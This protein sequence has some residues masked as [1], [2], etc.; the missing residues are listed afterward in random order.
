MSYYL[1]YK[2][3]L[4]DLTT[5]CLQRCKIANAEI[6]KRKR[7]LDKKV[8]KEGKKTQRYPNSRMEQNRTIDKKYEKEYKKEKLVGKKK[9]KMKR[10]D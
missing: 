5:L 4:K 8:Y 9:K 3:F 10:K 2:L 7:K 6:E 1:S